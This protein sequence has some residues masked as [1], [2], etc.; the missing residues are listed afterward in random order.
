MFLLP[1]IFYFFLY[2]L[3]GWIIDTSFRSALAGTFTEGS[4]FP[5]PLCP[6][7]GFGAIFSI[8][9]EK[10]ARPF[11]IIVQGFFY[12]IVLGALELVTGLALW[13]IFRERLWGYSDSFLNIM[14]YTDFVHIVAWGVLALLVVKY[15]HPFVQ[16][17]VYVIDR[18]RRR[19]FP[20]KT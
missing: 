15:I 14:G 13:Y 17:Y 10:I 16:K 4:F 19:V 3:A 7:Y 20:P 6:V 11:S 12:G 18:H 5:V 9:M 1:W 8:L 2:S